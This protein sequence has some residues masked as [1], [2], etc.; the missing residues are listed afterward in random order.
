MTRRPPSPQTPSPT[1]QNTQPP[2][3]NSGFSSFGMV[4]PVG[5]FATQCDDGASDRD[6]RDRAGYV[7]VA[8]SDGKNLLSFGWV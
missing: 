5:R 1:P 2:T 4:L 3:R 8:A 7:N 6:R